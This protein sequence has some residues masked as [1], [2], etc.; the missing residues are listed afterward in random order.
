MDK[1]K[2]AATQCGLPLGKLICE[3]LTA[4]VDKRYQKLSNKKKISN[5]SITESNEMSWIEELIEQNIHHSPTNSPDFTLLPIKYSRFADGESKYELESSVRDHKVHLIHSPF[6]PLMNKDNKDKRSVYDNIFESLN[7]ISDL[8]ECSAKHVTLYSP[9]R[10]S[11]RQDHSTSRSGVTAAQLAKMESVSGVNSAFF[12]ELH[13]RQIAGFYS[14]QNPIIPV[15]NYDPFPLMVETLYKDLKE[16]MLPQILSD[17]I[18]QNMFKKD[19]VKVASPDAGGAARAEH[20]AKMICTGLILAHKER[21]YGNVNKVDKV[22][23]IGEPTKYAIIVDDMIDTFGTMSKNIDELVKAETE[24]VIIM[25][26]HGLYNNRAIELLNEQFEK[27]NLLAVYRTDSIYRPPEFTK[28]HKWDRP[29][30]LAR[31]IAEVI[32]KSSKG[33]SVSG[34]YRT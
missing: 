32:Y 28:Q 31:K 20:I 21:D 3:E 1:I 11:S 16:N 14:A 5:S 12:T 34:V 19:L 9:Y 17:D 30:S 15:D 2:I 13:S 22:L 10:A 4:Y 29:V 25:S 23:L 33:H 18:E 6:E 8:K 7:L 27:G 24:K 26:P